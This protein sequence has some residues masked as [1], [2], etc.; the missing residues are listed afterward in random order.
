MNNFVGKILDVIDS[1]E[2]FDARFPGP[3]EDVPCPLLATGRAGQAAANQAGH[4][5]QDGAR[6]R[7]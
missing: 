1:I 4:A 7:A 3:G 6:A 5:E 2:I